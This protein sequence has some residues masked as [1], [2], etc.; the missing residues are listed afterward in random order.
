MCQTYRKTGLLV[1]H[2]L[3]CFECILNTLTSQ[4]LWTQK[5]PVVPLNSIL[6]W[7]FW[8]WTPPKLILT[9]VGPPPYSRGVADW[10]G[11]SAGAA[12]H[13][14][15]ALYQCHCQEKEE[16]QALCEGLSQ[17]LI[18]F[19]FQSFITINLSV[20]YYWVGIKIVSDYRPGTQVLLGIF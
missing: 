8:G 10:K 7:V 15:R 19:N 3:I 18:S 6:G 12:D 9:D 13:T 17:K 2:M 11:R 16:W 1:F 4:P 20:F 5:N 14:W